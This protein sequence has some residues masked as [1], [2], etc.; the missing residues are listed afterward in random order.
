[1]TNFQPKLSTSVQSK[2]G[3]LHLTVWGLV[4]VAIAIFAS[5]P[6]A[7]WRVSQMDKFKGF[8]VIGVDERY[9]P[10]T[11]PTFSGSVKK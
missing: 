4:G 8:H 11:K 9:Q 6:I 5:Y 2:T 7:M 10:I 3:K 1:M